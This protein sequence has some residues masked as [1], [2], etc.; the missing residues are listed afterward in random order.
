MW[1]WWMCRHVVTWMHHGVYCVYCKLYLKRSIG[2]AR[3][4][5]AIIRNVWCL[6][7]LPVFNIIP[8]HP[9]HEAAPAI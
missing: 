1:F 8:V 4:A 9:Y 2:V 7:C 6:M 3:V 5:L